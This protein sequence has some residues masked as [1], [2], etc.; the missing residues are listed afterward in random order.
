[1]QRLSILVLLLCAG[2]AHSLAEQT[3][4]SAAGLRFEIY[5]DQDGECRWRLKSRNGDIVA[6]PGEGYVRKYGCR[7]G[8]DV[9]RRSEDAPIIEVDN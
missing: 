3:S 5:E 9:V 6:T 2:C 1:M 7:H 4:W 8:I